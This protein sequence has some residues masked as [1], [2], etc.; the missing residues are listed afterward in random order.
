M[1]GRSKQTEWTDRQID[2]EKYGQ[3]DGQTDRWTDGWT[4]GPSFG[5]PCLRQRILFF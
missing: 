3:M 4:Y 2:G 1:E 5:G